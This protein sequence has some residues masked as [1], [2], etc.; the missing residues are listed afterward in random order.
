[1][2]LAFGDDPGTIDFNAQQISV[3]RVTHDAA[4]SS[5]RSRARLVFQHVVLQRATWRQLARLVAIPDKEFHDAT[6]AQLVIRDGICE[7]LSKLG[8]LVFGDKGDGVRR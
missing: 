7:T 1:M 5:T 8:N 4:T 6:H 2:H 3:E